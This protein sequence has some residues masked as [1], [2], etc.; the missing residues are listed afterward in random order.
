MDAIRAQGGEAIFVAADVSKSA[1]M[2]SAWSGR[3]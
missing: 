1:D 2:W 3:P